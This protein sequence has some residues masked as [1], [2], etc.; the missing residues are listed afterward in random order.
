MINKDLILCVFSIIVLTG[1]SFGAGS[2]PTPAP[3][4]NQLSLPP[5]L[6]VLGETSLISVDEKSAVIRSQILEL[7]RKE[8][9]QHGHFWQ[10][11]EGTAV[12]T[13]NSAFGRRLNSGSFTTEI[14]DLKPGTIYKVW[15]YV[16]SVVG[17][18]K[19]E[20]LTFTTN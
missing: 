8:I 16:E 2:L 20:P 9:F 1:C 11:E 7:G 13:L 5:V 18:V 12:K 17:S 19:G 10:E 14:L 6:P 15:P 3:D 4:Q